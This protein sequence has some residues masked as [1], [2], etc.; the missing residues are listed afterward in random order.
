MVEAGLH[1]DPQL[2]QDIIRAGLVGLHGIYV[3]C[4]LT[5]YL[6]LHIS[7]PPLAIL[8]QVSQL[9]LVAVP[10]AFYRPLDLGW[11]GFH[12]LQCI[13]H[14]HLQLPHLCVQVLQLL[15]GATYVHLGIADP[16]LLRLFESLEGR[17][18]DRHLLG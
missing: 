14:V 4:E 7:D 3:S 18:E 13:K 2:V 12:V 11:V 15:R 1:L 17:L 9:G 5:P 8:P 10:F 6:V 16:L